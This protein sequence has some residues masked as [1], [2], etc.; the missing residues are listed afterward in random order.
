[1]LLVL[2]EKWKFI[3][4]ISII[5]KVTWYYSMY[6]VNKN[7]PM[8]LRGIGSDR[9]FVIFL[10]VGFRPGFSRNSTEHDWNPTRSD[11]DFIGFC[12]IPTIS[13]SESDEI[14]HG[15]DQNDRICRSDWL[16]WVL[17]HSRKNVLDSVVHSLL[18]KR[19]S[20]VFSS[21]YLI[22]VFS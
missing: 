3:L 15:S 19:F 11:L 6:A 17:T 5:D 10:S 2:K 22:S 20:L 16:P 1:M 21:L 7:V 13:G 18:F 9:V 14:R 12:P 8:W 4:F